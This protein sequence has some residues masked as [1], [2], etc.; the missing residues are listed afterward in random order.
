MTGP[1]QPPFGDVPGAG[2][3]TMP[4]DKST[5]RPLPSRGHLGPPPPASPPPPLPPSWPPAG[6]VRRARPVKTWVALGVTGLS[7]I[8]SLVSVVML[9]SHFAGSSPAIPAAAPLTLPPNYAP[10]PRGAAPPP[11]EANLVGSRQLGDILGT[12]DDMEAFF[13]TPIWPP[14]DYFFLSSLTSDHPECGGV[15]APTQKQG[16][17]WADYDTTRSQFFM[18]W[19]PAQGPD[20]TRVPLLK[21]MQQATTFDSSA[22]A[23]EVVSGESGRWSKCTDKTV[24]VHT[25]EGDEQYQVA[26][27]SFVDGVLA[28]TLTRPGPEPWSCQHVLTSRRNVAI[29]VRVCSASVGSRGVEWAQQLA[30]R[31]PGQ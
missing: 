20:F 14:G 29:D 8:V 21:G 31:V 27:P 12:R 17:R 19:D 25:E 23:A 7:L 10:P 9:V 6:P 5:R 22:A 26:A 1:Q 4:I 18:D 30:G 13:K 11:K 24:T 28:V 3:R 2:D 16:Y 15:A